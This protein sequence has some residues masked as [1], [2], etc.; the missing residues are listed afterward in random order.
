MA[1]SKP[2]PGISAVREA[3]D[4][5]PASWLTRAL[6]TSSSV[7]LDAATMAVTVTLMEWELR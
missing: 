2:K 7:P 3:K 5:S 6:I 4:W 1:T